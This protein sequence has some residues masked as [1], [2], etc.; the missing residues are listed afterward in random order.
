[1]ASTGRSADAMTGPTT[2]QTLTKARNN[3]DLP[4][5]S[6]HPHMAVNPSPN[7]NRA[8][9]CTASFPPDDDPQSDIKSM[10]HDNDHAGNQVVSTEE[11]P[12][13]FRKRAVT[14]IADSYYFKPDLGIRIPNRPLQQSLHQPNPDSFGQ[15]SPPLSLSPGLFDSNNPYS[16]SAHLYPHHSPTKLPDTPE[17][18]F[19]SMLK[20]AQTMYPPIGSR[21][22]RHEIADL[23]SPLKSAAVA[24]SSSWSFNK[25]ARQAT[26]VDA[27]S[28][29]S[30][31]DS[32]A[33]MVRS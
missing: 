11:E 7:L 3:D 32:P 12:Y 13:H 5:L 10:Q 8:D 14:D 23:R 16:T 1:M 15:F 4:H 22:Y 26:Y 18:A 9:H 27:S 19:A 30:V 29:E 31:P 20:H 25:T 17:P 6:I 21:N 33:K 2:S 28:Y 24:R